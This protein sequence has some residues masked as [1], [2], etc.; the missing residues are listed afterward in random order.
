MSEIVTI[1]D[2]RAA[3]QQVDEAQD[4]Q[5]H[6]LELQQQLERCHWGVTY[7]L[8][9]CHGSENAVE[10]CKFPWQALQGFHFCCQVN[11]R[12][13]REFGCCSWGEL[14]GDQGRGTH[15]ENSSCNI[16]RSMFDFS[17]YYGS[18][19]GAS[20]HWWLHWWLVTSIYVYIDTRD[21]GWYKYKCVYVL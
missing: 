11:S 17:Q 14:R 19:L 15:P 9:I 20:F 2:L 16:R 18:H 8:G 21:T 12:T 5:L 4:V 3:K 1:Q 6:L 7:L 13:S 10:N